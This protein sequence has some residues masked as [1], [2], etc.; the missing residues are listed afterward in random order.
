MFTRI[1]ALL[2]LKSQ[3]WIQISQNEKA[4][5]LFWEVIKNSKELKGVNL[6]F[7]ENGLWTTQAPRIK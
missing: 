6:E 2:L 4:R 7:S 1:F 5:N 3:K